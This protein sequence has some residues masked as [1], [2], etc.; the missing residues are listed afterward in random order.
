LQKLIGVKRGLSLETQCSI[1]WNS[2][3]HFAKFLAQ[4]LLVVQYNIHA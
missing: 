4:S 1:R 3:A 2:L